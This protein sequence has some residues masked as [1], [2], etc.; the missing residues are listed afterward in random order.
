MSGYCKYCLKRLARNVEGDA[1]VGCMKR[2]SKPNSARE[3]VMLRQECQML[4]DKMKREKKEEKKAEQSPSKEVRSRERGRGK[5]K[6]KKEVVPGR[7][8]EMPEGLRRY[9][10]ER[11]RQ[12]E[13]MER[14]KQREQE[15]EDS[16]SSSSESD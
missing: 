13:E 9:H 6:E 12:K 7:K 16:F 11:R 1:C 2:R 3:I 5:E 10:E 14:Q 8:K 15:Q 4:K